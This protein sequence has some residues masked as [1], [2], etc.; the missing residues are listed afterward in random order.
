MTVPIIPTVTIAKRQFEV[1]I[2]T[3]IVAVI[4]INV[5]AISYKVISA[6]YI[7]IVRIIL[8]GN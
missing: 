5:Y 3:I 6:V 1:S 4:T 7:R 8:L 2:F